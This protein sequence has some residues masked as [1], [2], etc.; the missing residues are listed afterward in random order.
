MES[1]E[2]KMRNLLKRVHDLGGTTT[3]AQ[4]RRIVIFSM[5]A[6]WRRDIR[7]VPGNTSAD[8]FTYLQTLWYQREEERKE[9][10]Q[11]TKRVKALMAV[12]T[13]LTT[14]G[15]PQDQQRGNR[16]M[17]IC[18]NCGKTRHIEKRCWARGRGMEGQGP[19][20]NQKKNNTNASAVPP[21]EP[22]I[23]HLWQCT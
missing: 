19:R 6:E 8:A 20:N 16:S 12:H 7:T 11:D 18:H 4:F 2:K 1:H 5:P 21:N 10:E 3:D 17:V 9:E 14:L 23:T 15:Q 22:E 13:Q